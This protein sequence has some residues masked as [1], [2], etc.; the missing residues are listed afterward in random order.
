MIE[1]SESWRT[2]HPGSAFAVLVMQDF[3]LP[4]ETSLLSTQKKALEE[5][6][7][8]RYQAMDRSQIRSI[9]QMQAYGAFYRNYKKTYHIQ[10]QLESIVHKNKHLP[11]G[12]LLVQAMFMAEMETFLLTAG[13][14]LDKIEGQ[15][16]LNAATGQ[17]IYTLLRG[18]QATCKPGDMIMTDEMGVICSVIYGQ[19]WRTSISNDTQNVIYAIY[20]PKGIQEALIDEHLDQLEENVSLISPHASRYF[21]YIYFA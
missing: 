10:L 16:S 21:R 18:E 12:P 4:G 13:H 19:D 20:I 7:R 9:P 3:Q 6:L 8:A 2:N 1:V 5:E 17:E 11:E 14:D 15:M